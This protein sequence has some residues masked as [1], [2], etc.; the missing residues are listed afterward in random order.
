MELFLAVIILFV[1]VFFLFRKYSDTRLLKRVTNK[2]KGNKAERQLVLM[3]LKSG[4]PPQTIFHD[5]YV[6]KPSG[7]YSQI[8]VVVATKAGII[9]FEVKKYSGWIFGD[10]R[11]N[12]WTQ[13]LAYGKKKYRFY[14]P[15]KQNNKHIEALRKQSRQ[16][17]NIPF[18]SVVVFFGN[19]VLKDVSFI[20]DGTYLVKPYRV[21]EVLNVILN[22]KPAPYTDKHEVIKIL[23]EA[24]HNGENKE[25]KSQHIENIKDM[26][27]EHR[28]FD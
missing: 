25:I 15:I 16:L 6:K 14:N 17:Q 18:F 10:G 21:I 7:G 2:N 8:D 23:S 28:I 9:V 20:P 26:L 13:V 1:V 12:K 22:N 4:I 5:L 3:L 27:G 24:V 11:F 19:C